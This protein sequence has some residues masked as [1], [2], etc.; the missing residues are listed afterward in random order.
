MKRSTRG[1][2]LV[3]TMIALAILGFGVLGAAAAQI[4]AVKFARESRLRTEAY[5][6]AE[7]QMEAF[8][9]MDGAAIAD[10]LAD[11]DYPNDSNNP[12]DPDP[13]DGLARAFNRSWNIQADTP[14]A[15]VYTLSVTVQWTSTQGQTRSVVIESIKTDV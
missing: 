15:G 4:T 8:Q 5:Y 10:V 13:N 1:M 12:L 2:S 14:E 9:G 7:Q 6:L 3:E 11:S